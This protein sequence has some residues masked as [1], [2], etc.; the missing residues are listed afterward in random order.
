MKRQIRHIAADC[1]AQLAPGL[2]VVRQRMPF[3]PKQ[4]PSAASDALKDAAR[5][6]LRALFERA[7]RGEQDR[8]KPRP[9][10]DA[11]APVGKPGNPGKAAKVVP[12]GKTGSAASHAA[13]PAKPGKGP[14]KPLVPP[15]TPEGNAC[16]A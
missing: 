7:V 15:A 1:A 6:E 3:D 16:A 14:G 9:P 10:R 5:V 2:W 11:S 4:Y 8:V 12:A 13:Q